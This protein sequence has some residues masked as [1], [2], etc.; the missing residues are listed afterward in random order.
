MFVYCCCCVWAGWTTSSCAKKS[1]D[2]RRSF[3][4]WCLYLV[5][6]LHT[7]EEDNKESSWRANVSHNMTA[8]VWFVLQIMINPMKTAS[9][10]TNFCSRFTSWWKPETSWWTMWSLSDSGGLQNHV[11]GD[12]DKSSDLIADIVMHETLINKTLRILYEMCFFIFIVTFS[13]SWN[14]VLS[15]FLMFYLIY[16]Q[17]SLSFLS[18]SIRFW[19]PIN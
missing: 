5:G 2:W 9:E 12:P 16:V 14:L 8:L 1:L 11:I 6:F 19:F 15:V 17:W 18:H 13:P 3:I 4:N 10:K 7:L